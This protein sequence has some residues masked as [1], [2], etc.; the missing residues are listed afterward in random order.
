MIHCGTIQVR[1]GNVTILDEDEGNIEIVFSDA[2][3]EFLEKHSFNIIKMQSWHNK[4]MNK[5]LDILSS[6]FS[7]NKKHK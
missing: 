7:E 4:N 6:L 1:N 3:G 5:Q 2:S